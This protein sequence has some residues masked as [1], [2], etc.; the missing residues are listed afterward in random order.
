MTAKDLDVLKS[1]LPHL[2]RV[3]QVDRTWNFA[4]STI[5][6]ALDDLAEDTQHASFKPYNPRL[7]PKA[8]EVE[9]PKLLLLFHTKTL[10]PTPFTRILQPYNPRP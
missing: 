6:K 2:R 7:N 8:L 5:S 9:M 3:Q 4:H 10:N 1:V